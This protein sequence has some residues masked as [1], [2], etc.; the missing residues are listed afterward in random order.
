[1]GPSVI[2]MYL[3]A[4][5]IDE[6]LCAVIGIDAVLFVTNIYEELEVDG[7]EI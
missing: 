2:G 1:M 4:H 7:I 6:T 3:V 5:V